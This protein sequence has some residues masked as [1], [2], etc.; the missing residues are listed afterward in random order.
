MDGEFF[1][2]DPYT[3]VH[4]A[5]QLAAYKYVITHDNIYSLQ[6]GRSELVLYA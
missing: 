5:A 1:R 3:L 2:I 4:V 6:H